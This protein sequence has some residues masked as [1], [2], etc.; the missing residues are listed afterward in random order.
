MKN[1][2]KSTAHSNP[3]NPSIPQ[4]GDTNVLFGVVFAGI[5]G[6]TILTVFKKRK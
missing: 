5:A 3:V 2:I 4:T 6:T 1:E